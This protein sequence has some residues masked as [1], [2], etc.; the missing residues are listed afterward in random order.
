MSRKISSSMDNV[1]DLFVALRATFKHF[2]PLLALV[3]ALLPNPPILRSHSPS[4][5][6]PTRYREP[7]A[8]PEQ[9]QGPQGRHRLGKGSGS[10]DQWYE[11]RR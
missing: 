5:L 7:G 1:L 10:G 3:L 6:R 8:R 9:I 4:H 2:V 11:D